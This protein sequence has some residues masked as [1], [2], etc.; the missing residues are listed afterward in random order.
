MHA[1]PVMLMYIAEPA[2]IADHLL[3]MRA[4]A[5]LQHVMLVIGFV[6]RAQ[7]R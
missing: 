4:H 3:H 7:L 2:C 1:I 5:A 6:L